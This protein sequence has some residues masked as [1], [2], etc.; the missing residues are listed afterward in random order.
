MG[1]VA[2]FSSV[3]IFLPLAVKG[4][5]VAMIT[6]SKR[7]LPSVARVDPT[8]TNLGKVSIS[9]KMRM[10]HLLEKYH[11]FLSCDLKNV[12]RCTR[13]KLR[14]PLNDEGCNLVAAKQR[15]Y[16]PNEI[17]IIQADVSLAAKHEIVQKS[18]SSWTTPRVV[19]PK[20]E[21][22]D[23]VKTTESQQITG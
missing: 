3:H 22:L 13:G 11:G 9:E 21:L 16:T 17:E 14:L 6:G 7:A 20:M 2:D 5:P 8:K 1:F 15:R 23:F 19:V 4:Y 10:L 18:S 12:P